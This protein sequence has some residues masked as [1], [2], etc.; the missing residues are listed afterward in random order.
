MFSIKIIVIHFIYFYY[1]IKCLQIY[2]FNDCGLFIFCSLMTYIFYRYV[3]NAIWY[4]TIRLTYHNILGTLELRQFLRY[5]LIITIF[6][7]W[8]SVFYLRQIIV[9][10]T[11]GTSKRPSVISD[12][13]M[14]KKRKLYNI[15]S[16][17]LNFNDH[18]LFR[19][20]YT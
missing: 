13:T 5:L 9:I 19:G 16:C 17:L 11:S 2:K 3:S 1:Y 4:R 10:V 15:V 14:K 6:T 7:P 12:I 20:T 18:N 8:D